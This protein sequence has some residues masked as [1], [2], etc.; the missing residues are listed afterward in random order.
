MG[1]DGDAPD[2]LA[3]GPGAGAK[4][5]RELLQF[6][7]P[8]VRVFQDILL[9]QRTD[10]TP[11]KEVLVLLHY[12]SEEGFSRTDLGR[13]CLA[14]APRITESL[15]LLQSAKMRQVVCVEN[16]RYRLTDLG[17]KRIREQ[18]AEKLLLQ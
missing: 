10:F 11:G 15:Q 4:A 1:D 2:L 14:P 6:D 8:C 9:V 7:V 12:A 16:A 18:L 3:R 17:S 5:I 13:H